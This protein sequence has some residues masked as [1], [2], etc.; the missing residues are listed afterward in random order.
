MLSPPALGSSRRLAGAPRGE[1]P[2]PRRSSQEALW[3]R[4][5]SHEAAGSPSRQALFGGLSTLGSSRQLGSP[6]GNGGRSR[7]SSA[8]NSGPSPGGRAPALG[9][10]AKRGSFFMPDVPRSVSCPLMKCQ[11]PIR[12]IIFAC[13]QM[14]P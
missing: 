2:A 9:A 3:G 12:K 14:N 1:G 5:G 11:A 4:L 6:E 7:R 10:A 13:V 8:E